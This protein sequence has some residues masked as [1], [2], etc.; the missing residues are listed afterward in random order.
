MACCAATS[1]ASLEELPNGLLA[2]APSATVV[3]ALVTY[4]RATSLVPVAGIEHDI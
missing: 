3:R 1:L 2:V 4:F